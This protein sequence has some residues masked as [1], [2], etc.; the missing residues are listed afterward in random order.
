MRDGNVIILSDA[1]KAFDKTQGPLIRKTT[2]KKF[3]K[4]GLEAYFEMIQNTCE[5]PTV[6][7]VLNGET[8][9]FSPKIWIKT[10]MLDFAFSILHSSQSSRQNN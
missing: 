3:N 9:D 5:N 4:L 6:N 2:T 7:T 1:E 8:E 10:K